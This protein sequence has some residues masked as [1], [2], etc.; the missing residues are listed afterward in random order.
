[1]SH[2]KDEF[3]NE[4]YR[5]NNGSSKIN[6]GIG[7]AS[8]FCGKTHGKPVASE[9]ISFTPELV[10]GV[11]FKDEEAKDLPFV[12]DVY[13]IQDELAEVLISKHE[14]YGKDNIADAPGGAIN[15]I[16]VRM[17]DK[18]SRLNNLLD[19]NKSPNHESI[20]DTLVDLANYATIAIMVVDGLWEDN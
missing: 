9:S 4:Y 10:D 16:R 5:N 15:G 1:M 12:L 2:Y 18:L 14:D 11:W 20:R 17:H 3:F 7:N 13:D 8:C 19:N 6:N